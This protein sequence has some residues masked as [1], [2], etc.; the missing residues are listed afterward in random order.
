MTKDKE[1]LCHS[2]P[3]FAFLVNCS[4]RKAWDM[5]HKR[6]IGHVRVGR[7]VLIPDAEVKRFLEQRMVPAYK[8][9][10]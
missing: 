2:V 10:S 3:E 5:V 9:L 8:G 4:E 7:R 1:R 6:E